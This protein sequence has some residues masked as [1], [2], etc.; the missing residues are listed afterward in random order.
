MKRLAIV[1]S[2][3][4][5]YYS[6]IFKLL[7][8]RKN[9]ELKVYY[10]LGKEVANS[11]DKDFGQV[12]KW[13]IDLLEGYDFEWVINRSRTPGSHYFNGVVN[14]HIIEQ[15]NSF[16]PNAIL[17]FGWA[18]HGHLKALRYFHG[19]IPVYFR[20]D[21]ILLYEKPGL[22][23]KL[24]Y[25]FL[26]WVY[27]NVDFALYV[28]SNNRDYFKKYGI[29]DIQ[30]IYAPHAVD[31]ERFAA[32]RQSEAKALR[33]NLGLVE[34]DTLIL[35]AGK[36]ISKK[37]PLILIAAVNALENSNLHILFVG[38]GDLQDQMKLATNGNPNIHF[39]DFQNQ[40]V[41]PVVYQ[42]ADLFCLPSQG[43]GETW[44]LAVNEAMAA[45]KAVLISDKCGCATDLVKN[46][47]NGLI[48]KSN[49]IE[50][51]IDSLNVLC[52]DKRRLTD[53]GQA[54]AE[55]IGN[56]SFLPLITSIEN[57]LSEA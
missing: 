15:I 19:K 53:Y 7:A 9:I 29:K 26:K 27:R 17:V 48:F 20:G 35:F 22:K 33:I 30:L 5:Q 6:P 34:T 12:I 49:D 10:T 43:P 32:D 40:S 25:L 28:G 55:I 44:G 37:N 51:L 42:A 14:P 36:F 4:I 50:D 39:L 54:S 16:A 18:Y 3:P 41:M 52:I 21:S 31:N 11:F 24:K 2:H 38:N 57:L 47:I 8:E 1:I 45:S 23:A 56:F 46:G 13:D